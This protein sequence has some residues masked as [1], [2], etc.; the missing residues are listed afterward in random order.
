MI[1]IIL[2]LIVDAL[3]RD[4]LSSMEAYAVLSGFYTLSIL[5]NSIG[6]GI[7]GNTMY[8]NHCHDHIDNVRKKF[9]NAEERSQ[10][11]MQKGGTSF[12]AAILCSVASVVISSVTIFG[13]FLIT[14][15]INHA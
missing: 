13:V 12:T 6:F 2:N 1:I 7:N 11:L 5:V 10:V 15:L 9:T 14:A 4:Y 3:S 8:Y